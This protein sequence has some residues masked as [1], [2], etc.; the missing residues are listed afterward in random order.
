MEESDFCEETD[1][2]SPCPSPTE[3][4]AFNMDFLTVNGHFVPKSAHS[5]TCSTRSVSL[6]TTPVPPDE[7]EDEDEGIT[8]NI[9]QPKHIFQSTGRTTPVFTWNPLPTANGI[10]YA[11]YKDSEVKFSRVI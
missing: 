2:D 7:G 4:N 11:K 1:F 6:A 9:H 8:I 3:E 5:S 10:V